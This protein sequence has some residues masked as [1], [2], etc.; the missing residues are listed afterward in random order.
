MSNLIAIATGT[1][2]IL[3]H[4]LSGGD[5]NLGVVLAPYKP[6]VQCVDGSI[7]PPGSTVPPL[8]SCNAV[9]GLMFA[10]KDVTSFG[11][12]G[13]GARNIVPGTDT[14]EAPWAV[15]RVPALC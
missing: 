5:N 4:K 10:T 12:A 3:T 6:H 2:C 11:K 14:C 1:Q 7:G 8:K 9:V 15:V 13:S